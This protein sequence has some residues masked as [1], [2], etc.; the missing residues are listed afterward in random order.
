MRRLLRDPNARWYLTGQAFSL[1]G[2]TSLWL[3]L[4]I[5]VKE[6]T[7]SAAA[8]G[9]TFFFFSLSAV[10]S[11]VAGLVVDR[12]RRRPLLLWTNLAS[13]VMVLALFGVHG[14][15]QVWLI[16]VVMFLYGL[17]YSFLGSAQSALLKTMLPEELL[18]DANG[19]LRTVREG[20]RLIAPLVG[21][22]LFAVVGGH[23]IAVIDA[24]TFFIAAASLL[25]VH[26]D[27]TRAVVTGEALE[28]EA[29]H[30]WAEM[31]AGA[32]HIWRTR[33]LRQIV[34]G[35]S[36]A[37]LVVGFFESLSFAIVQHGLH[38][39][40]TF[41]GVLLAVQGC[42]A[43][44]G[45]PT[46]APFM[47]RVGPGLLVGIGLAVMAASSA[48]LIPASM[49]IVFAGIA[50]L[51]ISL[52]WVI[53]GIYTVLQVETPDDLQGR[54]YSAADTVLSVP[55]TVS[56]GIGA[57]LVSIVDYRLLLVLIAA[58]LAVSAL[59]LLTRREQRARPQP[60]FVG[61][62]GADGDGADELVAGGTP[63]EVA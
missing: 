40:P 21:A 2:D 42:G 38:R 7:G 8:A 11:P 16:Y 52:P 56:I 1:L 48:L 23:V 26:V 35:T 57:G 17:S 61:V 12:V 6:L 4:G 15:G 44:I 24:V 37:L 41:L 31:T 59:Y 63:S 22:A 60:A 13:G 47:R 43:H 46:A 39:A 3:A 55:Q 18:G 49:P 51:G 36:I 5:W 34:I 19:M 30:W 9:L 58:V 29:E 10:L 54:V 32:R 25:A 53:V 27:E 62:P 28:A 20:L 50:L 33:V 45:G 14:R